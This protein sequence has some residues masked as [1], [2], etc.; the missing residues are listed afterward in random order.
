MFCINGATSNETSAVETDL[1]AQG[2]EVSI[3]ENSVVTAKSIL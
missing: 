2:T 1:A 3:L